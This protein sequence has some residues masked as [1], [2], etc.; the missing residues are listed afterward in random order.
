MIP[1]KSPLATVVPSRLEVRLEIAKALYTLLE[2]GD[3]QLRERRAEIASIRQGLAEIAHEIAKFRRAAPAPIL[4][5]LRKYGY[6]PEEPRIPKHSTGGGRWTDNGT[7]FAASGMD[8]ATSILR[9]RGGHHFVPRAVYTNLPLKPETKKVF[10]DARTG[11]L[12]GARHGWDAEHD[13]YNQAVADALKKFLARSGIEPQD[14]TPEQALRF[15]FDVIGSNDPRIHDLNL[16]L[17]RREIL[18][19]ITPF[20]PYGPSRN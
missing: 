9:S 17:Y 8:D 11:P 2:D 15:V 7:Q 1:Y 3:E 13:A 4:S 19:Y 12:K 20:V 16:Q 14:M 18:R 10:D 5:E 6:N